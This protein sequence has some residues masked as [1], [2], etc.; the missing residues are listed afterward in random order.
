[1][2]TTGDIT[3]FIDSFA[4]FS[5]A[6]DFDNVG[7]LVGGSE[8]S[9]TRALVAL[10]ITPPVVE[11]AK[12]LKAQLIVSHHPVIFHPLKRLEEESV[13]Y[14]L[15][16]AGIAAL[17]AHTNLDMAQGGVNTCLAKAIGLQ[18]IKPLTVYQERPFLQLAV[19]V[20]A[21]KAPAVRQAMAEAG[22]G[23]YGNYKACS[24]TAHGEGAF[25]PQQGSHPAIGS[26]L[27]PERVE[28]CRVEMLCAPDK[29]TGVVEAMKKAHPYEQPAYQIV[30]NQAV[31]AQVP[32]TL[33]GELPQPLTPEAFAEQVKQGL[34]CEGLRYVPGSRP[35]RR[36]ALCSGAGGDYVFSAIAGGA[37]AFVT[38]EVKHHEL[39][40]AGQAGVTLV[41]AGHFKTETIVVGPLACRLRERFPQVEF[42]ESQACTDGVHFL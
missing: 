40:A 2:V 1:M 31:K 18:S 15:A 29:L 27:V 4:P 38:G 21:D 30:E 32:D 17:C 12:R 22:A 16:R 5:T 41:D 36:V 6:M 3:R 7:L 19:F 13:P 26:V 23:D 42:V 9:V 39:L 14:Q 10:D 37:D 25:T 24:F 20:P 33:I 35:V 8:A 34:A 11:E 28:E